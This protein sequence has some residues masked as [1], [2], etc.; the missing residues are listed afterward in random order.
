MLYSA[1]PAAQQGNHV[2]LYFSPDEAKEAGDGKTVVSVAVHYDALTSR[3]VPIGP[4]FRGVDP[5]WSTPAE[6]HPTGYIIAS[7][8]IPASLFAG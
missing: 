4:T 7:G 3:L 2:H 8:P 1:V 5:Q 6:R